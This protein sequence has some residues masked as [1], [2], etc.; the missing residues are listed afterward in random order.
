MVKLLS[1]NKK[2]LMRIRQKVG[3][4]FQNPDDQ[5]FAP[6]VLEDVAF[7]P[8]NMGLPRKK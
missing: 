1:Y 6:T 2:D 4:V 5:L 8:M 3:I 7:G